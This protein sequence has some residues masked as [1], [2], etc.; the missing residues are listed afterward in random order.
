MKSKEAR[1]REAV[2]A[3]WIKIHQDMAFT[4]PEEVGVL[5]GKIR[6]R[7]ERMA[8]CLLPGDDAEPSRRES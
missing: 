1:R 5:R 6:L 8:W 7:L 3:A 4:A 2:D